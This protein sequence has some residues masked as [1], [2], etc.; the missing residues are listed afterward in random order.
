MYIILITMEIMKFKMVLDQNK[1]EII[2]DE[3]GFTEDK[4]TVYIINRTT[5]LFDE[6]IKNDKVL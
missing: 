3:Q 6:Y 4:K 5:G 1:K 2:I